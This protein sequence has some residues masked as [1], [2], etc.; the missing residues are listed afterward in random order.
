MA[1][2]LAA[3]EPGVVTKVSYNAPAEVAARHRLRADLAGNLAAIDP[4][5]DAV[6]TP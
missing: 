3:S 4:L 1:E 6:V 2:D 5:T